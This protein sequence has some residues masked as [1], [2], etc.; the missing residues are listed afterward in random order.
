LHAELA[1]SP[2][3]QSGF[4]EPQSADSQR[5]SVFILAVPDCALPPVK[6]PRY[7]VEP[8]IVNVPRISEAG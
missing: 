3:G 4:T 5:P 2:E 7:P 1:R 8:S 6:S